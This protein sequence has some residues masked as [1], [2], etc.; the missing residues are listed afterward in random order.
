[1]QRSYSSPQPLI[2]PTLDLCLRWELAW[3]TTKR[4][5]EGRGRGRGGESSVGLGCGCREHP[6]WFHHIISIAFVTPRHPGDVVQRLHP[7]F[8]KHSLS[9]SPL[10]RKRRVEIENQMEEHKKSKKKVKRE[11]AINKWDKLCSCKFPS[12]SQVKPI[13]HELPLAPHLHNAIGKGLE[14]SPGGWFLGQLL[15]LLFRQSPEK[16]QLG[17]CL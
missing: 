7:K 12:T 14:I 3:Q 1:M 17:H 2:S 11:K 6:P 9:P 5:G 8:S 16:R 13:S 4:D 10:S 15:V